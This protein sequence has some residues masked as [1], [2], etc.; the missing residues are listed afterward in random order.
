[1]KVLFRSSFERDAKKAPAAL[2]NQL[3]EIIE[4]IIS[5][6]QLDH[7]PNLKKIKGAN[8]AYRIRLSDFRICFFYHD[9]TIEF[10]RFLPRKDVYKVFP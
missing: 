10:V 3:G 8:N 6:N 2:Q 9:K 7:I 1:M 5:A 4:V